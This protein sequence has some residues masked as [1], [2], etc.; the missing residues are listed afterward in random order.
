MRE[1]LESRKLVMG[2]MSMHS[3]VVGDKVKKQEEQLTTEIRSLLVS[4]TSLSAA[5]KRLQVIMTYYLFFN[6]TCLNL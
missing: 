4:G 6:F 3:K 5:N 1:K 2:N